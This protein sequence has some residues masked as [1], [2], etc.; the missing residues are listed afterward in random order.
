PAGDVVAEDVVLA[1]RGALPG[2]QARADAR[3]GVDR[4][5]RAD[6][7]ARADD[8]RQLTRGLAARRTPEDHVLP[9][10]AARSELH[11]RS[12]DRGLVDVEPDARHAGLT[13]GP[14]PC[15]RPGRPPPSATGRRPR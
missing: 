10:D 12:D 5:E 6:H 15:A 8:E 14:A 11:V 13:I 4:R 3:A 1:D 2:L 9:D 7:R